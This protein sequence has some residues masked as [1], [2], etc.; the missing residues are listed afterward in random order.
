[1]TIRGGDRGILNS[2]LEWESEALYSTNQGGERML[3]SLTS[4]VEVVGWRQIEAMAR[5]CRRVSGLG[6]VSIACGRMHTDV[7]LFETLSQ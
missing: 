1:M 3:G 7:Q 2:T 5:K 6:N 4:G